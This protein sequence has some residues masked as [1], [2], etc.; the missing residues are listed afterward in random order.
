MNKPEKPMKMVISKSE[1]TTRL[2]FDHWTK[3]CRQLYGAVG[4]YSVYDKQTKLC[5]YVGQSTDLGRRLR[6][7]FANPISSETKRASFTYHNEDGTKV[8]HCDTYLVINTIKNLYHLD[9]MERTII[10]VNKPV[11]NKLL[12]YSRKTQ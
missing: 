4:V 12:N 10:A 7:F 11:Y 1:L 6:R 8:H 5:L 2:E 3:R 9:K